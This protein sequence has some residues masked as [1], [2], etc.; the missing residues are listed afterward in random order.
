MLDF[1]FKDATVI[2][3]QGKDLLILPSA[4][5]G[6]KNGRI[7]SITDK[8]ATD[9]PQT[10]RLIDAS[11]KLLMPGLVNT[12]AHLCMTLLRGYADDF[13][14]LEWLKYIA[15]AEAAT[16]D[17]MAYT[18]AQL[19][20]AE[21]LASG[22]TSVSDMDMQL[23][24]AMRAAFESGIN[25][26]L[27]NSA[28][29]EPSDA[30]HTFK[31]DPAFQEIERASEY[32]MADNGRI[33]MDMGIHAEY[34]STASLCQEIA[35]YASKQGMRI[36]LHMSETAKEHQDCIQ[37]HGYT[38]ASFFNQAGVFDLPVTA[39]HCVQVTDQDIEILANKKIN[40]SHNPVS[41]LKLASGIAPVNQLLKANVNVSLGSD[42]ACSNN[43]LNLFE[44]LKL[45][46]LL[47]KGITRDSS[48]L[49]AQDAFKAATIN[50]AKAQ[51]RDQETG[52]I[53]ENFYADLILLDLNTPSLTPTYDPLSTVVYS[54]TAKDVCLTMVRG[55][56]LY[57][58]GEH[59]TLDVPKLLKEAEGYRV[60][61]AGMRVGRQ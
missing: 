9:L 20:I 16:D 23:T 11:N 49:T 27:C 53:K 8:E 51:G 40:V 25:A 31:K 59:L 18:A 52:S 2:T 10:R 7:V 43:S 60:K 6:I 50:G 54:A 58:N 17:A 26:S 24:Q 35:D 19:G 32:H 1:L 47:Q 3:F 61:L 30:K 42:S 29:C 37:R 21:M 15:P 28:F 41:N 55:R 34:T 46:P 57:E 22:I 33:R 56:V 44:E 13:T 36:Q 5:V 12:H 4:N 38:P 39:A 48:S 45:M 14:L